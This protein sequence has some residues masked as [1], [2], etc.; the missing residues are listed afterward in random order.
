ML[1]F[2]LTGIAAS[3]AAQTPA[4][5]AGPKTRTLQVGAGVSFITGNV[6]GALDSRLTG[7]GFAVDAAKVVGN[8]TGITASI[9]GSFSL[10]FGSGGLFEDATGGLRIGQRNGRVRVFGQFTAGQGRTAPVAFCSTC[11]RLTLGGPTLQPSV[12]AH[13]DLHGGRVL[14]VQ[15]DFPWI[16]TAYWFTRPWFGLTIPI[17]LQ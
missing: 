11:S 17:K 8:T 3:A 7:V 12:G 4:S 6:S 13:V 15:V 1:G 10:N 9:V 5:G 2:C 14:R 16:D